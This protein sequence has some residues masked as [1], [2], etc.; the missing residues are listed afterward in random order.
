V[1]NSHTASQ[2]YTQYYPDVW[3]AIHNNPN[4]DATQW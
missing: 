4:L 3:A 1:L 2:R